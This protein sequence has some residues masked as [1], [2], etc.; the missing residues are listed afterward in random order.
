LS[1]AQVHLPDSHGPAAGGHGH[2]PMV[3]HQFDDME[4]KNICDLIGMWTFLAT[5]VLFFGG[6]FAALMLYRSMYPEAFMEAS[7]HL[8]NLIGFI[9]TLVLLTSSFTV[10]LSVHAAKRGHNKQVL[11]WVLATMALA[12]I[13]LVVKVS[14]E[15]RDDF[16][17]NL[18]PGRA[19]FGLNEEQANWL[20]NQ[21]N[22][23]AHPEYWLQ[24]LQQSGWQGISTDR[25]KAADAKLFMQHAQMFFVFYYTMTMIHATHMIVGIGIYAL[26]AWKASKNYYGPR[27]FAQIEITGLYWHFVDIVW[28]FLFPLLYLIR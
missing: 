1:E 10:V 16:K 9:N 2:D 26:L 7:R 27:R 21:P 22:A 5:E 19:M 28:I 6:L 20:A 8:N 18:V 3:P 11:L 24:A 25:T 17:D 23:E 12:V 15:Y 4:Q 14:I 13:F